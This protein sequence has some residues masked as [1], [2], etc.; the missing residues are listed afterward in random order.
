[1]ALRVVIGSV[2][3]VTRLVIVNWFRIESNTTGNRYGIV[4]NDWFRIESNKTG[5][6]Y[7]IVNSD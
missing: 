7:S 2:L 5:N 1:M 6:R 3:K 4:N